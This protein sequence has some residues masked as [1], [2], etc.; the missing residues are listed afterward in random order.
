MSRI[1]LVTGGSR[2]GKSSFALK[3]AKSLPAPRAFIA[4]CPVTDEEMRRRIEAHRKERDSAGWTT[5]EEETDLAGVLAGAKGYSV[6]V[7]DCLTLWINNLMYAAE[8][9]G[10]EVTEADIVRLA[11]ELVQSCEQIEGMVIFVTNEVGMG[12]VPENRNTRLYRDL[13]G[14]CGQTIAASADAVALVVC[15]VPIIIKGDELL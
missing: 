5:I 2:S 7:V 11:G 13:V 3:L 6:I 10:S 9:G 1:I 14:R 4:T 15:G 12:I 8:A